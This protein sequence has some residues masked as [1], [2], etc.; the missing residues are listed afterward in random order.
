MTKQ[1]LNRKLS[2]DRL[3]ST[4]FIAI[5]FHGIVIL[6]IGFS[7]AF[8]KLRGANPT[9]EVVLVT[10]DMTSETPPQEADYLAQ[11]NM[12]GSGEDKAQTRSARL[13]PAGAPIAIDGSESGNH[14]LDATTRPE[15][16][17]PHSLTAEAPRDESVAAHAESQTLS[18]AD[19]LVAQRMVANT[20]F[21]RPSDDYSRDREVIKH[22]DREHFVSVNTRES[23]VAEYLAHWKSRVERLGTI[24]FPTVAKRPELS[25]S[26][27][28]EV[29]INA[30]GSLHQIIVRRSS[31][32]KPLD[33]AALEILQLAS[34]FEPFPE[35]LRGR[36]DVL[37]F[38]YEWR[39]LDG[40]GTTSAIAV[41][42]GSDQS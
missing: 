8:D 38:A 6:G 21:L 7:A 33:Q 3:S 1:T 31:G 26:P 40:G 10:E 17:M 9:L 25:G 32:Y 39:F 15:N 35:K 28:L 22:D 12:R 2:S 14:V 11:K 36:Y 19:P 37:R 27:T 13:A 4:L 5:L 34:P 30:D 24:R 29:A 41:N 42:S 20:D 18:F 23:D 16:T